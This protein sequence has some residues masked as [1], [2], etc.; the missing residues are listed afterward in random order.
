MIQRRDFL[1]RSVTVCGSAI[2]GEFGIDT[3]GGAARADG[4]TAVRGAGYDLWFIGAQR[5]TIMNGKLAAVL[6]LKT[7]ADR[8]HLMASGRSNSYVARLRSPIAGPRWRT[9][10]RTRQ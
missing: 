2:C 4:P 10:H 7:L 8:P 5:E 3:S 1:T 9:S 6:D